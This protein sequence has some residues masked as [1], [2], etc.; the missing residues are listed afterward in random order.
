MFDPLKINHPGLDRIGIIIGVFFI[1][2]SAWITEG[3][4]EGG[5]FD[6]LTLE[7]IIYWQQEM[8]RA[9]GVSYYIPLGIYLIFYLVGYF[10]IY[11][12]YWIIEGF[13]NNNKPK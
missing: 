13:K 8:W 5:D 9:S 10:L 6:Q 2:I 4:F 12:I 1:I 11:I 3:I 7:N